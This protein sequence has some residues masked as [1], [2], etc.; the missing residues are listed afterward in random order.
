QGADGYLPVEDGSPVRED[1][2][3]AEDERDLEAGAH[4]LRLARDPGARPG[5]RGEEEERNPLRP[6]EGGDQADARAAEE[7][8]RLQQV[9]ERHQEGLQQEDEVPGRLRAAG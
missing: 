2:L 3:L 6:G 9:V 8:G 5:Q 1:R 7:A 4:A